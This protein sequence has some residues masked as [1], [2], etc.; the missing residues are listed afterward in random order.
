MVV[1]IFKSDLGG[2]INIPPSKS[3]SHRGI[4]CAALSKGQSKIKNLVFSKDID[5]SIS[6]M[7]ALGS[8]ITKNEDEVVVF[9]T[10]PKLI[11]PTIHCNESGSTIRFIIPIALTTGQDIVFTGENFLNKRPQTPYFPIMDL[12]EIEYSYPEDAFLP[13]K[14]SGQLKPIDVSI[15]GNISSQF[16]SG[17]MFAYSTFPKSTTI[18]IIGNLES[19]G[20]VDLTIDTLEKFG[21]KITNN[22]YK[23][24]IVH[25]G[26]LKATDFTVEGDFS[27]VA[28]YVLAGSL[29][30]NITLKGL[31]KNSKQGDRQILNICQDM[32][33]KI[34][35]KDD[36]VIHKSQT[37]GI[38]M[39]L[40]E[41]PDLGPAL[42]ALASLSQ[43][44]T[45]I[46]GIERLRIKECDRVKAMVDNLQ[47]LGVEAVDG[48]DYVSI[49]GVKVLKG[50][51]SLKGYND[52]RIVMALSVLASVCREPVT[53]DDAMAITKSYPHFY[54][55]MKSLG[56]KH[57]FI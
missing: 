46:R 11:E 24:F 19:K 54:E 41:V 17:L 52:H 49:K 21:V 45:I 33:V 16:I 7:E 53:I 55:D 56:L 48:G 9:G 1:K 30:G 25:G 22:N 26:T 27:Q 35:I 5:A 39:N 51:V 42:F 43:G 18:N 15:E 20:Y 6:A 4:I 38:E 50:G 3:L 10:K 13:L 32:G 2:E 47:R 36:V 34:D 37:H 31:N 44:E 29:Q 40:S 23:S 14:T 12:N 8:K 57:E 28:F